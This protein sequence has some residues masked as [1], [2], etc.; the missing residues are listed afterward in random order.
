[1]AFTDHPVNAYVF[2]QDGASSGIDDFDADWQ[3]AAYVG[4]L[5]KAET[6]NYTPKGVDVTPD[7]ANNTFDATSG[8]SFIEDTQ[9]IA[10]RN[11]D[12]SE[13][14]RSG[15]W[16][17]GYLSVVFFEGATGIPFETTTGEN[18]VY[19]GWDRTDQNETFI[20]V[21]DTENPPT[22]GVQ[23]ETINASANSSAPKNRVAGYQWEFLGRFSTNGFVTQADFAV[24]D[25]SFD[26]YKVV[27][28]GV[29][30]E[31]GLQKQK[32]LFFFINNQTQIYWDTT[33]N[34]RRKNRNKIK[35]AQAKP[36]EVDIGGEMF[37]TFNGDGMQY[38]N[39]TTGSEET[40]YS[41]RG[42]TRV[43]ISSFDS[44]QMNWGTGQIDGAWNIWARNQL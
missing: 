40:P 33:L 28:K 32:E 17:E 7:F 41:L 22:I 14:N 11:W 39:R 2:P 19:L 18:F 20:R 9:D 5:A 21:A 10:F 15:L 23:I 16:T 8:L 30:G 13:Q 31:T 3:N 38:E 12:D 43:T 25:G 42:N 4:G 44:F 35:P 1:M 34:G 24:P 29:T 37:L 26:E 6:K 27:F 36:S